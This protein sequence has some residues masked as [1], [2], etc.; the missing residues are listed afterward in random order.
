MGICASNYIRTHI[1]KSVQVSFSYLDINQHVNTVKTALGLAI[2]RFEYLPDI[3]I[4]DAR[5]II[6]SHTYNFMS[7]HSIDPCVLT[8][9][10]LLVAS[11]ST[12]PDMCRLDWSFSQFHIL[13]VLHH[14]Y[15][16]TVYKAKCTISNKDV[17]VKKYMLET[18]SAL[19]RLH[20]YREITIHSRVKHRNIIDF[21]VAFKEA[22][23]VYLVIEY[24]Q[25]STLLHVMRTRVKEKEI[26]A[27]IA[28][29]LL[30][31]LDY[32]H[33][34]G[35]V[36]RDIKPGNIILSTQGELK[37]L[38]FGLTIDVAS[39][40]A[41][42]RAGTLPYMAPE[43]LMCESKRTSLDFNK[44]DLTYTYD[45]KSDVWALGVFLYE[46]STGRTP[47]QGKDN[48][49]I[50]ENIAKLKLRFPMH[51][52]TLLISFLRRCFEWD[53]TARATIH[54]LLEHPWIQDN[55]TL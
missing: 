46:L 2:P 20:L 4:S 18:M 39:E 1:D 13:E 5:D 44:K 21:Y 52:S 28:K 42:T 24:V 15:V 17:V 34:E 6:L 49:E 26:V 29:P 12:P 23:Q 16:S 7:T 14:G 36:H 11:L 3:F 9:S 8:T 51:M 37:L 48:D 35:I 27:E 33:S 45:S 25:G 38:D 53:P 19:E 43:I 40:L 41:N 47:F 55:L 31:V 50:V 54:Q 32:L 30:T 10:L 22:N